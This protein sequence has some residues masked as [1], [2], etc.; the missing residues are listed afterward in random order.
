MSR[1]QPFVFTVARA[2]DERRVTFY[3]GSRPAA[4]KLAEAWAWPRGWQVR[5]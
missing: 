5:S 1:L 4:R 2:D 3:A